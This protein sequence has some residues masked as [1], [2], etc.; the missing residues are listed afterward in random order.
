MERLGSRLGASA[1][2]TVVIPITGLLGGVIVGI[3][4]A[5]FQRIADFQAL[6]IVVRFALV[7]SFLGMGAAMIVATGLR[8]SLTTIRGLAWL[9]AIVAVLFLFW[10]TIL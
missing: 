5:A 8:N 3:A 4:W 7:G 1:A 2:A 9:I 10:S 6:W